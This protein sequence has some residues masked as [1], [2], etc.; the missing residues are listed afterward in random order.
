MVVIGVTA[1]PFPARFGRRQVLTQ[2]RL[3]GQTQRS[4]GST[5]LALP[6][7]SPD[8]SIRS[9]IARGSQSSVRGRALPRFSWSV[10]T[11][12]GCFFDSRRTWT[13]ASTAGARRNVMDEHVAL[14]KEVVSC[15]PLPKSLLQP[16]LE[17]EKLH[18]QNQR[19]RA[20]RSNLKYNLYNPFEL[21]EV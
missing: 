2:T 19:D 8:S 4:G 14:A 10:L 20:Y 6:L 17:T 16:Q 18:K 13:P 5:E 7:S 12:R 11:S 3:S 9:G 15:C 1:R 21:V